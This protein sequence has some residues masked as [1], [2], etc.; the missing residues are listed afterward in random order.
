M[1]F[2][3]QL[4]KVNPYSKRFRSHTQGSE[5]TDLLLPNYKGLVLSGVSVWRVV[6]VC[7]LIIVGFFILWLRLF[8]LQVVNGARHLDLA[9]SNRIRLVVIHAPRGVI[10][11]RNGRILAQ[12]NP[13]FRRE[14]EFLTRDAALFLE[15][16]TDPGF[17]ELEVDTIRSYP[18]SE[19][20]AHVIGYVGQITDE[21]LALAEFA[22]YKTGDRIGRSGIEQQYER[23][24]KGKDG[25]E[26]IEVDSQGKKLRLL[27]RIEPVPGYNLHLSIDADLQR[28]AFESLKI[29]L[30][31]IGVC[32]GAAV[33][34]DPS[35][36]QILFMSSVPSFDSNSFTDPI[37]QQ[38]IVSYFRSQHSPLLNRAISGTYP[39]GSTFK[40]TS[41]LAALTSGKF[42]PETLIEDTGVIF[43]GPFRF[44]N[45]YFTG[46]GKKDGMVNL[47]K[48]L[49]R[50][51]DIY[52]YRVGE[53][54]GEKYLGQTAKKIGFGGKLG[55]DLPEE[56]TGLV[57]DG[58]WKRETLGEEWYPGDSLH[59]AIG[60][61]FLLTTPL[62]ILSQTSFVAVGGQRY[63]PFLVTKI[64]RADGSLVRQF[65]PTTVSQNLFK[66]EDIELVKYGLTL[67]PRA[68]GTAWP[69]FSFSIPTAGKTG[70]AEF[71][72][73]KGR[74]HAWYTSFAPI[75]SPRIATTVLLEAAGE[76]STVA[77]PVAHQ[78]Y[79]WYFNSDKSNLRPLDTLPIVATQSGS[80]EGD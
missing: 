70:T 33:G 18:L 27:R 65:K 80:L 19:I 37:R 14:G 51:N 1:A 54:V 34:Q 35:T 22:G 69:F 73:P 15:A 30:E 29:Q 36:G 16:S 25:A 53:G 75:D 13:G 72:D 26:I 79:T 5:W 49:Q 74:T 46:Y 24:L 67:V 56:V 55:I 31:R 43:L 9:D 40:I 68:G 42:T 76:G 63:S 64:T 61:G 59:M 2:S 3:D 62:Q 11:D 39:P 44:A 66:R 4:Q 38:E 58:V 12:S 41:A 20:T 78:I 28:V 60:Q 77:A 7:S 45:W 32:C 57:P 17:S 21:E 50:S 71:G 47:A 8:H 48:A 52:F 6:A 10:Y 23:Y